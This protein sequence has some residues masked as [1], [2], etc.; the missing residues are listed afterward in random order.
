MK[1]SDH[2]LRI[3]VVIVL[4][5]LASWGCSPAIRQI[6]SDAIEKESVLTA[7]DEGRQEG[8]QEGMNI[9]RTEMDEMLRD[10]VR[11]YRDQLL[12]LELVKGGA[13]MP[14]QIRLVYNPAKISGDGSSYSAPGL[15]WKIVSPPQFVSDDAQGGWLRKD[16]AN[17]CYFLVESIFTEGEAFLFL[18]NA[19]KP[20]DV[21]LTMAPYG[22]GGRWAVIAK[23][24]K[25]RCDDALAFYKKLGRQPIRID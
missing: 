25:G 19:K 2:H 5:F 13:I 20:D 1:R 15:T 16:R 6:S 8:R 4:A 17:F 18:G 14:A 10:F 9:C 22:D 3:V 24:F 11:K 12:Y 21:F 7:R 23:A